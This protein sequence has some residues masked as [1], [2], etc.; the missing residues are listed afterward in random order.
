MALMKYSEARGKLIHIKNLNSKISCQTP[1]N[2][3]VKNKKLL[4][5]WADKYKSF[6]NR[7]YLLI[8]TDL[9]SYNCVLR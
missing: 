6:Y 8:C 7:T 2:S 9:F 3:Y 4:H 5:R 1:F